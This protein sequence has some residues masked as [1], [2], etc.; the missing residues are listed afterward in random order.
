MS[1]GVRG[2]IPWMAPELLSCKNLVTEKV[3]VFSFGIVM[4]ELL[5][6]E[7]PYSGMRSHEIIAGIIKGTLRPETPAWWCWSTNPA[8]R[9]TF[10]ELAKE[11]T[12]HGSC[13]EHQVTIMY[14]SRWRRRC[15]LYSFNVYLD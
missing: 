7:E 11:A 3:D 13:Y 6:R 5:T 14:S 1:G 12:D 15:Q 4:W 8:N 10:S 9:P 2:T